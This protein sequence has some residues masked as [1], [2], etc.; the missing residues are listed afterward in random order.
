[1]GKGEGTWTEPR[2][3]TLVRRRLVVDGPINT[4]LAV[5]GVGVAA[6]GRGRRGPPAALVGR[7]GLCA[8]EDQLP[9]GQGSCG[10]G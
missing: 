5:A 10:P 9:L 3:L 2:L 4:I 7:V 1:M 8:V 6:A